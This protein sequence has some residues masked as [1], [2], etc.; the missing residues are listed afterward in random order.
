MGSPFLHVG[1]PGGSQVLARPQWV[2]IGDGWARPWARQVL[3][4]G[5]AWKECDCLLFLL[6]ALMKS[7]PRG[8]F[9]LLG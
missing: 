2:G 6:S 1:M 3:Q 4:L 5:C 7:P 9:P 8:S